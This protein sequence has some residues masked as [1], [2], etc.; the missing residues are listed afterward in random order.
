M[1]RLDARVPHP[2]IYH[3]NTAARRKLHVFH[4]ASR[5]FSIES[6]RSGRTTP[7]LASQPSPARYASLRTGPHYHVRAFATVLL[8]HGRPFGRFDEMFDLVEK[9][10][11]LL[12]RHPTAS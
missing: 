8:T 7:S 2:R 6:G 4:R 12:P 5:L 9:A 1:N 3:Q 10:S 11:A